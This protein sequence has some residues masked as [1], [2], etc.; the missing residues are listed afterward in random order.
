MVSKNECDEVFNKMVEY[1]AS[2]IKRYDMQTYHSEVD[3]K[4]HEEMENVLNFIENHKYSLVTLCVE[5]R[6][7]VPWRD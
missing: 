4:E 7:V 6:P 2:K 3:D 1:C 5:N